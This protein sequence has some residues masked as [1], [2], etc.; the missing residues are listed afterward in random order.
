MDHR[1]RSKRSSQ[2]TEGDDYQLS[3]PER[4]SDIYLGLELSNISARYVIDAN[5]NTETARLALSAEVRAIRSDDQSITD[6]GWCSL[7]LVTAWHV[8]HEEPE[9]GW[10]PYAACSSLP[11]G[12]IGVLD[13]FHSP[14]DNPFS[15]NRCIGH[16]LLSDR[17]I[18][19]ISR[20]LPT[21]GASNI[22]ISGRLGECQT[23]A[24]ESISMGCSTTPG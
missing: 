22:Q 14:A 16:I 4:L 17:A 11:Q 19:L 8:A 24:V 2:F 7:D 3:F 23:L 15:D 5:A 21:I 9:A 12:Y 1:P 18:D 6:I 13:P 10:K 20:Q